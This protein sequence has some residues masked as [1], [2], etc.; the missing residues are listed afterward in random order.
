M[1]MDKFFVRERRKSSNFIMKEILI[2]AF[3]L[4]IIITFGIVTQNYLEKTADMLLNDIDNLKLE[5]IIAKDNENKNVKD[6]IAEI[7]KKWEKNEKIWAN[8]IMHQELDNIK[9]SLLSLKAYAENKETVDAMAEIER[10][11]FWI[12]HIKEKEALKIKNIF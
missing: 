11:I 9:I 12:G 7:I 10:S 4:A 1:V 6:N 2:S 3:I 8:I 5:L